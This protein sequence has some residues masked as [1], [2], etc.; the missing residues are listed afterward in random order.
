[1]STSTEIKASDV[2][3]LRQTTGAGLMDCKRALADAAGDM[4]K[5]ISLLRERGIAKSSKRADRT[6][7]EG[8]VE[9]WISADQKEGILF[10][11]NCETDFVARNE[12][13]VGLTKKFIGLIKDNP[14]WTSVDQL[15][16]EEVLAL[17]GKIGEKIEARRFARYKTANG[18]IAIYIHAG[19]KLGVMVQ[20]DSKKAGSASDIVATTAKELAIQVAGAM[21]NYIR[22]DEVPAEILEREKEITKKQMEGQNKPAEILEKIATGKLSQFFAA[23]CLLEQPYV[24]DPAGK[25]SI[26]QLVDEAAKKEGTE[27]TVVKFARFRVGAE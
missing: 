11:M 24:R 8:L 10:E 9:S 1:M 13:F 23:Q 5:A 4:E 16:K 3:K 22:R 15:P 14:S 2:Q 20:I 6:A 27:L 25:T 18:A 7:G 17:S 21:P 19:S 26:Q 12:E